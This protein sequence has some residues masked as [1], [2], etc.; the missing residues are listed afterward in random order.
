MIDKEKIREILNQAGLD[1]IPSDDDF[2]KPLNGIG[3]DSLDIYNFLS[4]IEV[5]TGKSISDS[6]FEHL[7]TLND[8]IGFFNK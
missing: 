3:L 7:D 5:A 8:V 1:I 2:N 6:E 4:E